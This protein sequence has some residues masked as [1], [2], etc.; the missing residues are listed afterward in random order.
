V[1]AYGDWRPEEQ[2]QWA[3][4]VQSYE[5]EEGE[6]AG[7]QP[8]IAEVKQAWIVEATRVGLVQGPQDLPGLQELKRVLG[9]TYANLTPGCNVESLRLEGLKTIQARGNGKQ[10]A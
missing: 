4:P 10:A 7:P 9:E 2:V 6:I 5:E 1:N 3:L 8:T